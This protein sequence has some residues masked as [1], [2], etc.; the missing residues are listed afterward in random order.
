[1]TNPPGKKRKVK[2]S[3]RVL[4]EKLLK[5]IYLPLLLITFFISYNYVFDE[6]VD[7]GGDNAGYYILGKSIASGD[8]FKNIHT[9]EKVPHNHFPPGYPAII[10]FISKIFSSDIQLIKHLNGFFLIASIFLLFSIILQLSS[11]YHIAFIVSLFSLINYHLLSFSVIIMSEIPFMFFSLLCLWLL[12]KTD[13]GRPAVKNL[14][15]LLLIVC[16]A[17]TYHVR[18]TG[19]ALFA[20]F[21]LYLAVQKHWKY[22]ATFSGGFILLALPWVIRGIQVGGSSYLSQLMRKNPYRPELGQMELGDWF[23]RI[24]NNLERYISREIPSGTFNYIEVGDY[25]AAVSSSEWLLGLLLLGIMIFGL[26]K[27]KRFVL[28]LLF[29]LVASFGIL[30]LWPDVWYG[31]RFITPLIPL[32]FYV[33]LTGLVGL[34]EWAAQ[35]LFGF[36][37]KL[38]LNIGLVVLSLLLVSSYAGPLKDLNEKAKQPYPGSYANYFEL[39]KWVKNNAS[40][41]SITCCR[42]GQLFYLF[43]GKFVVNYKNTLNTEEQIEH[44]KSKSVDYVVL[45]QLGFS[46]TGRY[47][48]PAIQKYPEKFKVVVQYPNP[49]TYLMEFRPEMGYWG[50]WQND[51]KHGQGVYRYENGQK[52]DGLWQN[53]LKHG[54][55]KI[56]FPDGSYLEGVWANDI[57]QGETILRS[58]DGIEIER[59]VYE[60]NVKIRTIESSQ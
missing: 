11:S 54:Q 42:K 12:L 16:V 47:L 17:F 58:A 3:K 52:F 37:N 25:Q 43:S 14:P 1:M 6:K 5:F 13:F 38:Y 2:P 55:G 44:L 56:I 23:T 46:S 49:D 19:L 4:P 29:Y 40:D 24:W 21:A 51:L 9:I 41:T 10:A 48:Y 36:S 8:G 34:I 60:N 59:S 7:M 33:F 20:G 22:L 28:A 18:S 57:L 39:A 53:G 50:E 30:M 15:F 31:T 26:F 27:I 45:E 35:K 32:L